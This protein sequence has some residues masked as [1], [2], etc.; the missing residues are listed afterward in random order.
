MANFIVLDF[1]KIPNG[2]KLSESQIQEFAKSANKVFDLL[3]ND[4][5]KL[6]LASPASS[7]HHQNYA[8]GLLEH[9]IAMGLWLYA[10]TTSCGGNINLAVEECAKIALLH[11]LCKVGLYTLGE[12]GVYRSD[13]EMYKHH[14]L[15]SVQRCKSFGIK[16]SRK[17]RISILL[18]MAGAWWNTEDRAALS[19]LDKL[20]I[21]RHFDIIAAVQW[22]DMKAC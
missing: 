19:L 2:T 5:A 8:G 3:P 17:E 14:A 18:H 12:D 20:W 4:F 9:C 10:K 11:D 21:S 22:A 1:A 7:G 6:Y 13:K 15:L 16:L